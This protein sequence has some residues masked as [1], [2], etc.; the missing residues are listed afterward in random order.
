MG[1]LRNKDPQRYP[2]EP[3]VKNL[4]GTSIEI[5]HDDHFPKIR[6]S[7][8][9]DDQSGFEACNHSRE[10]LAVGLQHLLGSVAP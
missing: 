2:N 6:G 9:E 1:G 5:R 10:E 7:K 4:H 3:H 8:I